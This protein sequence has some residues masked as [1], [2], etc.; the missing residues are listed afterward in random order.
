MFKACKTAACPIDS[1]GTKPY[2][3]PYNSFLWEKTSRCSQTAPLVFLTQSMVQGKVYCPS[4]IGRGK[5]VG[6]QYGMPSPLM[7][8]GHKKPWGNLCQGGMWGECQDK[9]RTCLLLR[10]RRDF[11]PQSLC[12]KCQSCLPQV[13][14]LPGVSKGLSLYYVVT[15]RCHLG[16]FL[17]KQTS[18]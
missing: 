10:T 6:M 15:W 14:C 4:N 8:L 3:R 11:L 13:L 9:A 5:I 16:L 1:M 7:G 18:L 17:G 2:R 12:N